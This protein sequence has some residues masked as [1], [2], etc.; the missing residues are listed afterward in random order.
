MCIVV[1]RLGAGPLTQRLRFASCTTLF[2]F[3]GSQ[4]AAH[5]SINLRRLAPESGAGGAGGAVS[6]GALPR[7]SGAAAQSPAQSL[8]PFTVPTSLQPIGATGFT[9]FCGLAVIVGNSIRLASEVELGD[10]LG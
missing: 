4:Y 9:C 5:A 3:L 7:S 2:E 8:V 1:L 10:A 6:V